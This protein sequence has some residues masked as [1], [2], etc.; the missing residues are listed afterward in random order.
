LNQPA[1]DLAGRIDALL[2]QTQCRLCGY[3]GCRPYAEAIAGGR[4]GINQCPPG[5]DEGARELA[6]LVSVAFQPVDP[7]YGLF[8]PPAVA[9][10]DETLCIGCTLCIEACPVDAIVGAPKLMHTV[11]VHT[12]TG[13]ELCVAPCPVDCISLAQTGAQPT[14]EERRIAAGQARL[15]FERRTAR[16]A[17]DRQAARSAGRGGETSVNPQ[18]V[19]RAIERARQRL[20]T[21]GRRRSSGRF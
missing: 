7:R 18:L 2:P 14:R 3:A 19:Q 4:A 11:I 16:G 6:A 1:A 15:R 8:K 13:C 12:C 10:I 21:R 17:R 5:G 9:V 20:A